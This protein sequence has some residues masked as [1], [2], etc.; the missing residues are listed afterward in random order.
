MGGRPAKQPSQTQLCLQRARSIHLPF[1]ADL[2][3]PLLTVRELNE[4][5]CHLEAALQFAADKQFISALQS[6]LTSS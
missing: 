1:P 5:C 3:L 4:F 2:P 6:S